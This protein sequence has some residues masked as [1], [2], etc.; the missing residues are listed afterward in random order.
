MELDCVTISGKG[1]IRRAYLGPDDEPGLEQEVQAEHLCQWFS[2]C[3]SQTNSISI[4][5]QL[6]R[7]AD[8]GTTWQT[9]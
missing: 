5:W 4:N 3:G 9:Y 7:H 8:L 6:A 2:K 1:K